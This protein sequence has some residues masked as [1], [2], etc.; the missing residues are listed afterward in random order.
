[1]VVLRYAH[2]LNGFSSLNV[3]KLDVLDALEE[4]RIGVG[5]KLR[6]QL[7]APGQVPSVLEDLA[8]VEVV[9]ETMPGW[10]T[11]TAGVTKFA[12]LPKAAQNYV[13]RIE[14]LVG[15]PVAWV[16]TGPG[17]TEMVARGFAFDASKE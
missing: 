15:V 3:T 16:G 5:Y 7:L 2:M 11:S 8:A 12:E 9:Y 4:L 10:K 6:G 13:R 14:Q 1:M 17:R